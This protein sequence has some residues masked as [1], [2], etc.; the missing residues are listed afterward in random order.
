[1]SSLNLPSRTVKIFKCHSIR[2]GWFENISTPQRLWYQIKTYLSITISILP[3]S[4]SLSLS[5]FVSFPF[6]LPPISDSIY[7]NSVYIS[8]YLYLPLSHNT[9]SYICAHQCFLYI[10]IS[11]V[12]TRSQYIHLIT[13]TRMS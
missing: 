13:H 3:H 8:K 7:L 2:W 11:L 1:M 4:L 6:D 12:G 9:C 5:L 10:C